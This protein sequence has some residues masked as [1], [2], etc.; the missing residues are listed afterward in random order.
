MGTA[1]VGSGTP[2]TGIAFDARYVLCLGVFFAGGYLVITKKKKK[3][4]IE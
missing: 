2:K 1:Q 3:A 4:N